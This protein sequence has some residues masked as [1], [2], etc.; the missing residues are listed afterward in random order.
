MPQPDPKSAVFV[1]ASYALEPEGGG[2]QRCTRE[3]AAV[4]KAAGFALQFASYPFD[5]R[6]I[7]RMRRMLTPAPYRHLI[8]PSFLGDIVRKARDARAGWI[9]FNQIEAAPMASSLAFLR[10]EGVRFALFSHGV[11]SSDYLHEARIR[12]EFG[13]GA[14][15]SRRDA[16]WLGRQLFTEMAQHRQF[17]VVFCLSEND[18][19]IEQWLGGRAVHALPR[20]V[21]PRP[22]DWHPV[23][24]R[25]G[26][27]ATLTHAPNYE[28][29]SLIGRALAPRSAGLTV[30]LVGSPTETGR[31]L[32]R[33]FPFIDFLGPLSDAQFEA[34]ARSWCAFVNPVFCYARGCST[35]LAVP[36]DWH[37]PVATTRAGARGYAWDES[38]VPLVETPDEL[39]GLA[40][41]LADPVRAMEMRPS[42][43]A[44]VERSPSLADVAE[45]MRAALR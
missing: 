35:K 26:T 19:R 25:L 11:D 2:V 45:Q 22:L 17:D 8:P 13:H 15:L 40:V 14:P 12:G 29:I 4:A 39:A 24:G 33:E 28:G 32:A 7:T 41:R 20:V 21:E 6:L 42:I 9:F 44:L 43:A 30:R 23:P 38:L 1:S 3:Y 5:N 18:R 34:E 36:L 31:R 37:L 10:G 27:V 16:S